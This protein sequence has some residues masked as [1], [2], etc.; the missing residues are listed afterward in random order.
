MRDM[1][2]RLGLACG[3]LFRGWSL[4]YGREYHG[5]MP[6]NDGANQSFTGWDGR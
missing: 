1:E 5:G 3:T 6:G 2:D 4:G